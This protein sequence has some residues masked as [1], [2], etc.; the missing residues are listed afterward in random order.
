MVAQ[1][2]TGPSDPD[3]EEVEYIGY[4][5]V[6]VLE[7]R[8]SPLGESDVLSTERWGKGNVGRGKLRLVADGWCANLWTKVGLEIAICLR[9]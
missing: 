3:S 6:C 1:A 9:A 5:L 8:D 7:F 2:A 4:T